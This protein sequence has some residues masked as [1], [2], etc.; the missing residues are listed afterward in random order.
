MTTTLHAVR[1]FKP[2][3]VSLYPFPEASMDDGG[4][5]AEL[6]EMAVTYLESIGFHRYTKFHF[7]QKGSESRYFIDR[8]T[9]L[10][11]M[12]FG[13]GARSFVDDMFYENTADWQ[14][15]LDHAGSFEALVAHAWELDDGALQEYRGK[16]SKLLI[17]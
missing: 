10:E 4:H 7:A 16:A 6:Q 11:Y 9:G 15:Y 14:E 13:L 2:S 1:D 8:Y 3:H 17:A 5:D 12:G